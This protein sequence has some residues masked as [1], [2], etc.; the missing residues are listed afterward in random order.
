MRLR[1]KS[2][3][4]SKIVVQICDYFFMYARKLSQARSKLELSVLFY[5]PSK[6]IECSTGNETR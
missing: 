3:H 6:T 4:A 1:L 5:L 2:N